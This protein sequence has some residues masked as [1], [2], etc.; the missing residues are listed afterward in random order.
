MLL[1]KDYI[2]L[3]MT[4]DKATDMSDA[5][6]TL[7]LDVAS[8][9]WAEPL[10]DATGLTLAHMPALY[11]GTQATG[12][13]RPEIAELWGM[14]PVPVAAGGSDNAAGAAG[15]GIVS[16][17]D[18]LLSL[19]TSGVIFIANDQFKPN[20]DR[21]VHAFCHCLPAHWHQMAVHL[22]APPTFFHARNPWALPAD[23]S[24]SSPISPANAPRTTT[25][26]CAE[27]S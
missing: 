8:R 10:L 17:G 13:L 9:C 3:Q 4:G 19:G 26:R 6:G 2:R 16:D 23:L 22:S 27:P 20:P 7:W 18:G 25:R 1:P 5:A 21:T 15:I 24:S 11:E 12:T 14:S